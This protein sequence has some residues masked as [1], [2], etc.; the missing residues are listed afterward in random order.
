MVEDVIKL[1]GMVFYGYHGVN[2]EE[3]IKGQK[4]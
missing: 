1:E 2:E 3:K 4:F